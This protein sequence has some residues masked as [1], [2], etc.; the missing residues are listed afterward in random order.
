MDSA[1]HSR[2]AGR[3]PRSLVLLASAALVAGTGG[4]LWALPAAPP[5]GW[6]V[7]SGVMPGTGPAGDRTPSPATSETL[8]AARQPVTA[9]PTPPAARY[10]AFLYAAGRPH[11]ELAAAGVRSFAMGHIVVGPGG[12]APHWAGVRPR[13]G[14]AVAARILRV[15]AEGGEV[16]PSFGGPYGQELSVT[17]EDPALLRSAYRRVVTALTA[18]GVDFEL[19]DPADPAGEPGWA[20]AADPDGEAVVRRRAAALARLQEEARTGEMPAGSL[21]VTFTVPASR[22]GLRPADQE[23][24]RITREA[25]V[26]ID[27][28]GLLVPVDP[29]P[30]TLHGLAVAVRAARPQI[31]AA[32]GVPPDAAWRR[33]GLTPVLSG[34]GDLGPGDAARL[35][36]FRARSGLAWLS[37]RGARPA[38]DVVRILA[39]PDRGV[40]LPEVTPGT[41]PVR[42][43]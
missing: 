31:A 4:A 39:R 11:P 43:W 21:R 23:A 27:S 38:D 9:S 24:L 18:P 3:P 33:M 17:C 42:P 16:W 32:L 8:V 37:L 6:N 19:A 1:R 25:G 10:R 40:A 41:P 26:E 20:G 5:G 22:D 34:S 12:C 7:S 2:E 14:E 29:G 13:G 15:R 30:A 36:A 28:V 35:A